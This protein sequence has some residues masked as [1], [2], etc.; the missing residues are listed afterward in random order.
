MH[1]RGFAA[2]SSSDQQAHCRLQVA[3]APVH[4]TTLG[5]ACLSCRVHRGMHRQCNVFAGRRSHP[6]RAVHTRRWSC[7]QAAWPAALAAFT[8]PRTPPPTSMTPAQTPRSLQLVRPPNHMGALC[9]VDPLVSG[10]LALTAGFCASIE[11]S[12]GATHILLWE[13]KFDIGSKMC[14]KCHGRATAALWRGQ[15]RWRPLPAAPRRSFRHG[16]L[17]RRRRRGRRPFRQPGDGLSEAPA[18]VCGGAAAG[19]ASGAPRQHP[20]AGPHP[21]AAPGARQP[22]YAGAVPPPACNLVLRSCC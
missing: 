17:W 5:C 11:I 21:A 15:H 13:S 20:Q 16:R 10:M 9:A 22:R 19:V 18:G 2:S 6:W 1:I 3:E 12:C 8:A 7:A 4:L 14:R